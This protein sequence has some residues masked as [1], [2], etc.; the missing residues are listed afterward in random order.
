MFSFTRLRGADPVLSVEM[1]STGEVA[2][3][4]QTM[5]EAYL[6]GLLATRFRLPEKNILI[7]LQEAY[8]HDFIHSAYKLQELGYTLYC[9]E[10]THKFFA[11]N[12]VETI[13]ARWPTQPDM[14]GEV[15]SVC[16]LEAIKDGTIHLCINLPNE[17]SKQLEDNYIIR[18][19]AT[20]FDVSLLNDF[21]CTKLFVEALEMHH[22][23][24]MVGVDPD[25]LFEYYKSENPSH[26]WVKGEFH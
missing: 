21:V 19:A 12:G 2:C 6:K 25:S 24:P 8:R 10:A 17:N 14:E 22:E 15:S 7:S 20:D 9:T 11:Q 16:A 1:T 13:L 5:H 18:R 26:K 23:N 3:F 4:G